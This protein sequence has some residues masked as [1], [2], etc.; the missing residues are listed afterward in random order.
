M[1]SLCKTWVII[2]PCLVHQHGRPITW[3][4]FTDPPSGYGLH[5]L[6]VICV[7]GVLFVLC[8]VSFHS[9][10]VDRVW[11]CTGS[12][13]KSLTEVQ[14]GQVNATNWLPFYLTVNYSF[15]VSRCSLS[16]SFQWTTR[17]CMKYYLSRNSDRLFW[18]HIVWILA[19]GG[20]GKKQEGISSHF[21]FESRIPIQVLLSP[22]RANP[23]LH[24]QWKL[25]NKNKG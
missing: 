12:L 7:L 22:W 15:V 4:I 8:L 1:P 3:S 10:I 20:M 25:E 11:K 13:I 6:F 9:S 19:V 5:F 14:S 17:N 18:W 21:M 2:C 24:E 16:P 23:S